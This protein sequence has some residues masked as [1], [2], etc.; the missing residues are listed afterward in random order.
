MNPQTIPFPVS[1]HHHW[2]QDVSNLKC[3]VMNWV[4][5]HTHMNWVQRHTN[6]PM[7]MMF[8][9][10]IHTKWSSIQ[11]KMLGIMIVDIGTF[12]YAQGIC[13][14]LSKLYSKICFRHNNM[15]EIYYGFECTSNCSQKTEIIKAPW[16]GGKKGL[17]VYVPS[18]PTEG[19]HTRCIWYRGMLNDI[20]DVGFVM[21]IK[22]CA[23]YRDWYPRPRQFFQEPG[24]GPMDLS[25]GILDK[26]VKA[27]DVPVLCTHLN[28]FDSIYIPIFISSV[29]WMWAV[30]FRTAT[31]H[32]LDC[33]QSSEWG[34]KSE[35][36]FS[37]HAMHGIGAAR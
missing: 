11:R 5:R 32:L 22:I 28:L 30:H 10:Y 37:T 29:A 24:L 6:I 36:R 33:P 18:S 19:D 7:A 23:E 20:N 27:M 26:S 9:R 4:Q 35:N 34:W 15:R 17:A 12:N 25:P 31:V 16:P 8:T 14:V 21:Q 3:Y 1:R 13:D 2:W